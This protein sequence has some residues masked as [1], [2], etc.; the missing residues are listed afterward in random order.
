M[1]TG[2][3][4]TAP[5]FKYLLLLIMSPL[6]GSSLTVD[7]PPRYLRPGEIWRLPEAP[8]LRNDLAHGRA[9]LGPSGGLVC[10]RLLVIGESL[11]TSLC[12]AEPGCHD[13]SYEW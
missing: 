3:P 8:N 12:A 11:V 7:V 6:T 1:M 5:E 4:S 13:W 2:S 10:Y 9:G